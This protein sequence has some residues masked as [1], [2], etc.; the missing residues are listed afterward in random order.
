MYCQYENRIHAQFCFA[1][2]SVVLSEAKHLKLP[3]LSG[4]RQPEIVRLAQNDNRYDLYHAEL[5]PTGF[6]DHVLVPRR[7]PDELDI[8]FIDAIDA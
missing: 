4:T 1:V 6:T 8:G 3:W 5:H 2:A 7:I